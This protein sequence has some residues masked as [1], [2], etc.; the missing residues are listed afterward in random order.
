MST[1]DLPPTA[2]Y[3]ERATTTFIF[4]VTVPAFGCLM[5][6]TGAHFMAVG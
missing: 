4:F 3:S 2:P 6:L 5:S 1:R